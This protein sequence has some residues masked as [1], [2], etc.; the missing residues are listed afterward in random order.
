LPSVVYGRERKQLRPVEV[1]GLQATTR[2]CMLWVSI[3]VFTVSVQLRCEK[4]YNTTISLDNREL[5]SVVRSKGERGVLEKFSKSIPQTK[6]ASQRM[7]M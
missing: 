7:K 2:F 4:S 6:N 5:V 3:L 1:E